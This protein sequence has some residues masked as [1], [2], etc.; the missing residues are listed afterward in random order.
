M[1]PPVDHSVV[2]LFAT[3]EKAEAALRRLQAAGVDMKYLSVI[4]KEFQ[5]GEHAVGFFTSGDRVRL[6]GARGAA[7]GALWGT[8]VGSAFLA[9]PGIGPLVV[10]GPLVIW[11]LGALETA[12]IGAAVGAIAGALHSI[13]LPATDA[14]RYESE[15]RRGTF[16]VLALGPEALVA[17]ARS[18]LSDTDVTSLDLHTLQPGREAFGTREAVLGLLTDHEV[19]T[20]SHAEGALH[21]SDGDEYLDL[22]HLDLGV[23]RAH[24]VPEALGG[25]LP[26]KS[27]SAGTWL[28]VLERLKGSHRPSSPGG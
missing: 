15:L 16:L 9:L 19:A 21:L 20:V 17:Q 6:W 1:A 26:K 3:H 18:V 5:T 14:E 4:G 8:L 24:R 2:A 7:W 22:E 12:A 23:L 13:G 27:V 11:V 28:A 10:M 25:I